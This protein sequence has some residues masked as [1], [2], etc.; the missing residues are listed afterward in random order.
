MFRQENFRR[1]LSEL[2]CVITG[3][4]KGPKGEDVAVTVHALSVGTPFTLTLSLTGDISSW[5]DKTREWLLRGR[6]LSSLP[7]ITREWFA[8]SDDEVWVFSSDPESWRRMAGRA[9]LAC[10]RERVVIGAF[11]MVLN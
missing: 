1:R 7:R 3:F 5:P 4:A 6:D 10:V 8:N 9:G 2:G 11:V